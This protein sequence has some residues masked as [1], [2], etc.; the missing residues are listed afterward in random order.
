M[1][2]LILFIHI[3]L[4]AIIWFTEQKI[5]IKK[6]KWIVSVHGNMIPIRKGS[7]SNNLRNTL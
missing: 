7:L 1:K 2:N 4:V 3:N 5:F 6:I